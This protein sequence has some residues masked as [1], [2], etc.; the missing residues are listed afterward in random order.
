[1]QHWKEL[2][3]VSQTLYLTIIKQP[4]K[5]RYR[6]FHFTEKET[7]SERLRDF[8]KTTA[9]V[10]SKA[11]F[12]LST[13]PQEFPINPTHWQPQD[14]PFLSGS[15]F[16]VATFSLCACSLSIPK[17]LQRTNA[18]V[19]QTRFVV[20]FFFFLFRKVNY[21]CSISIYQLKI[22]YACSLSIRRFSWECAWSAFR[23]RLRL[24]F[25]ACFCQYLA[26]SDSST[27]VHCPPFG[28]TESCTHAPALN[29]RSQ[30]RA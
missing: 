22:W 20:G 7:G 13:P 23:A 8:R 24:G 1:M 9:P 11:K 6:Y 5:N 3:L 14:Q 10:N 12:S 17:T 28:F 25:C 29:L 27:H 19:P 4:C 21:A 16:R 15:N 2:W 18:H 30:S 26:P